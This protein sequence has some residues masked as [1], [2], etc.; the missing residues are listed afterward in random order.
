MVSTTALIAPCEAAVWRR[1]PQNLGVSEEAAAPQHL[2]IAH[3]VKRL[4]AELRAALGA[5]LAPDRQDT[6]V[7]SRVGLLV[8]VRLESSAGPPSSQPHEAEAGTRIV[9]W[10]E[11]ELR[12]R[13]LV[14]ITERPV[15]GH[16]AHF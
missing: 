4:D 12:P 5:A 15:R 16:A 2:G 9:V 7:P 6:E 11:A 8:E 3:D 13:R 14:D 10:R 1:Q